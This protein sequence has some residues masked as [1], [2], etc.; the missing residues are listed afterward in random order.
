MCRL[1]RRSG[2]LLRRHRCGLP[3][4]HKSCSDRRDYRGCIQSF[5]P[6]SW[7]SCHLQLALPDC[8]KTKTREIEAQLYVGKS[9]ISKGIG[10]VI[11]TFVVLPFTSI[12]RDVSG[13]YAPA[14]ASSDDAD[15]VALR[16]KGAEP[17]Q[18]PRPSRRSGL[19]RIADFPA[20][21]SNPAGR[22]DGTPTRP[23]ISGIQPRRFAG[24]AGE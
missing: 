4:E 6:G 10:R 1:P 21:C 9:P 2:R 13:A 20:K 23:R 11:R 15:E 14:T 5:R 16:S 12:S 19:E 7:T 17:V 24:R 22:G 8:I 3:A 18:K